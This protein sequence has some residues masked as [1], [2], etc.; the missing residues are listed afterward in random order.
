MQMTHTISG[1][2]GPKLAK[3]ASFIVTGEVHNGT[4]IKKNK[5]TTKQ[6]TVNDISTPCLSACVD[7]K[8]EC[9]GKI[10]TCRRPYKR[11]T[12]QFTQTS[13]PNITHYDNK[14]N[15]NMNTKNMI[16]FAVDTAAGCHR[17]DKTVR[18]RPF[19]VRHPGADSK[20]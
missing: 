8:Q 12:V 15:A 10:C 17:G 19:Q 9:Q 5:K 16:V 18:P 2:T 4:D 13:K 3:S 14:H 7:N 11:V 6:K 20:W 1:V